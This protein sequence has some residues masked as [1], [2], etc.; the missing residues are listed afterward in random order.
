MLV[1]HLGHGFVFAS[2]QRESATA[3]AAATA[4]ALSFSTEAAAAMAPPAAPPA[5]SSPGPA[6]LATFRLCSATTTCQM[7]QPP[8]LHGA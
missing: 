1:R 4:A 6:G 5:A 2:S 3:L 7:R 8:Q